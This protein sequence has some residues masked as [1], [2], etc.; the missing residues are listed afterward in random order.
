MENKVLILYYFT[1]YKKVA[2]MVR[3]TTGR[4]REVVGWGSHVILIDYLCDFIG[5][6]KSAFVDLG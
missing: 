5:L 4:C 2:T 1:V 6:S 3:Q